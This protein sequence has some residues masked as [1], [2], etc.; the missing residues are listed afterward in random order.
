LRCAKQSS[1]STTAGVSMRCR[2]M[3]RTFLAWVRTAIAVIAF[4]FLVERFDL[5]LQELI[6]RS[7]SLPVDSI[8]PTPDCLKFDGRGPLTPCQK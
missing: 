5:F 2:V 3:R 7:V 1:T 6:G 4:G 8:A